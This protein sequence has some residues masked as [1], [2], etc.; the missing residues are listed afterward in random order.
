MTTVSRFPVVGS[1]TP[2]FP[3]LSRLVSPGRGPLPTPP[4]IVPAPQKA[5]PVYRPLIAKVAMAH[6]QL[7][8]VGAQAFSQL[9]THRP[10]GPPP[11]FRP[12]SPTPPPIPVFR[13]AATVGVQRREA[14]PSPLHR[15]GQAPVVYRP[16]SLVRP[17][18]PPPGVSQ[19]PAPLVARVPCT[20]PALCRP[21]QVQRYSV[22]PGAIQRMDGPK[23]PTRQFE[24]YLHHVGKTTDSPL[25]LGRVRDAHRAISYAKSKIP[26]AGNIVSHVEKTEGASFELTRLVRDEAETTTGF[27][28]P[29][30]IYGDNRLVRSA[31][32][33]RRFGGGNCGEHAN[34]VYFALLKMNTGHLISRCHM[35]DEVDHAFVLIG[36]PKD[37][38]TLV[39]ADAW[40]DVPQAV[41]YK[42][43]TFY[44][45]TFTADAREVS[46]G[47]NPLKEFQKATANRKVEIA[48]QKLNVERVAKQSGPKGFGLNLDKLPKGFY[49]APTTV[50]REAQEQAEFSS[51]VQTPEELAASVRLQSLFAPRPS[52]SSSSSRPSLAPPPPLSLSGGRLPWFGSPPAPSHL[53]PLPPPPPRHPGPPLLDL[54]GVDLPTFDLTPA[55]RYVGPPPPPPPHPR[56][57]SL[58]LTG[59]DLPT[60]DPTPGPRYVGPP[61]PPPPPPPSHPRRLSF[62]LTGI[63]LPTFDPTPLPRYGGPPPPPPPPPGY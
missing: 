56:L 54:R 52:S 41:L 2:R 34:V 46:K 18:L 59:I 5:P 62:D 33:A 27:F 22:A 16:S 20:P 39:V 49:N 1:P 19:G 36:D 7:T 17:A 30:K 38:D 45:A 48:K 28:S 14:N 50:T 29:K 15:P 35:T 4:A 25:A 42:D 8:G 37:E 13:P 60:F 21:P 23:S 43:W 10:G 58:D 55:P 57:P 6:P 32:S 51:Y 9:S 3:D 31:I 26:Y 40:A 61:P 63:D 11:V 12:P 24:E 47:Q 44:P 53:G